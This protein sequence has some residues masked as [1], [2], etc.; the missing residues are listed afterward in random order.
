YTA[1]VHSGTK[2]GM[3]ESQLRFA[4]AKVRN[5]QATS[6]WSI[7]ILDSRPLGEGGPPMPSPS[8]SPAMPGDVLLPEALAIMS[9]TARKSDDSPAVVYYDRV[10][11]NLRY[12]EFV[13]SAS[14][15]SDPMILDGEDA[16]ANDT[17]DVGQYPSLAFDNSDVGHVSYVD[18]THDDL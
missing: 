1:I 6:D 7:T 13:P 10:R 8:A 5:P 15:W 17:G 12:V 4:Q 16:M 11:G 2:S 14:S 3:P 9:G 18:A